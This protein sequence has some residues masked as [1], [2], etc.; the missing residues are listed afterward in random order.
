MERG[1][2]TDSS[3]P[4]YFYAILNGKGK[5]TNEQNLQKWRSGPIHSS[6]N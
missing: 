5:W 3:K 1:I 2:A 4:H 6:I